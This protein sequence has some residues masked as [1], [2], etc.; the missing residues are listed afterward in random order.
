MVAV[1]MP[2]S[3]LNMVVKR[4]TEIAA[5]IRIMSR[6]WLAGD[7]GNGRCCRAGVQTCRQVAAEGRGDT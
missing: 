5:Q 3:Q 4:G 1:L 2:G 7:S 6:Y